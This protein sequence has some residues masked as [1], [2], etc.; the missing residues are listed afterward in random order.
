MEKQHTTKKPS[1]AKDVFSYLLMIIMLYV[2]VIS[3][4]GLLWQYIEVLFPDPLTFYYS[5][6][7]NAIRGAISSLLIVWPVMIFMS[8]LIGKD[9]KKNPMKKDSRI[10]KW[11]LYLTVF[12]A[13]ITIIIDLITVTNKFLSGDITTQF[14]LKVLAVLLVAAAVFGYYFWELRRDPTKNTHISRTAA[15]AS[16]SIATIAIVVGFF[17]VGSPA[18]QRAMRFDE[19]RVQDLQS[20]QSGILNHWTQKSKIP[21]SLNDLNDLLSGYKAPV[22]PDTKKPYEYTVKS[23]HSFELCATFTYPSESTNQPGAAIPM[24]Y[25][26]PVG[27]NMDNWVHQSGRVCFSRTIDP[28]LYKPVSTTSTIPGKGM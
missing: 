24:I 21:A 4:V 10:R 18:K 2:G 16:A 20:I 13:A 11:L 14:V 5:N 15:I 22:D 9:L 25:P 7:S 12:L 3:F 19:Q 23:D 6:A 17:I 8:W 28:E 26:Y 27:S 1:A